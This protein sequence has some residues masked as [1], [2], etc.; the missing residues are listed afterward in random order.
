MHPCDAEQPGSA[1]QLGSTIE[2]IERCRVGLAPG[3]LERYG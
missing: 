2:V 3:L 1:T